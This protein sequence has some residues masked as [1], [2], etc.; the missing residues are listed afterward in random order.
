MYGP[1]LVVEFNLDLTCL[2]ITSLETTF[3]TPAQSDPTFGAAF[4]GEGDIMLTLRHHHM[5]ETLIVFKP[6]ELFDT[7]TDH[8]SDECV[9]VNWAFYSDEALTN[10]WTDPL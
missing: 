6:E 8:P 5:N 1:A 4:E 3:I 7:T 2:G 10:P 9:F